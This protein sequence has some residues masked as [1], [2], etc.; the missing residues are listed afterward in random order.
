MPSIHID[1]F[2]ELTDLVSLQRKCMRKLYKLAA[3]GK[4]STNLS[5]TRYEVA[6]LVH[7]TTYIAHADKHYQ[8]FM[9]HLYKHYPHANK[10]LIN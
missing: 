2:A 9:F 7:H 4:R 1:T 5:L 3:T 6:L 10:L 8:N